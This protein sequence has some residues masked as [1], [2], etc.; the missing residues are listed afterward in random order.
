MF[1]CFVSTIISRELIWHKSILKVS[2]PS[3]IIM[4]WVSNL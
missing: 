4:C 1:V 2:R 3:N